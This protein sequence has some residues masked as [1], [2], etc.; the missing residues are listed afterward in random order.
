MKMEGKCVGQKCLMKDTEQKFRRPRKSH[1]GG[2]DV[3]RRVDGQGSFALVHKI[4]SSARQRMGPKLM[5]CSQRRGTKEDG[6]IFKRILILEEEK[7]PAKNSRG[8]NIEGQKR[9]GY[10]QGNKYIERGI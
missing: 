8:W 4:S 1:M 2:H 6:K 7:V 9:R 10:Q 5:D 3:V